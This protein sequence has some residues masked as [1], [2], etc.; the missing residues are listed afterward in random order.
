MFINEL[1]AGPMLAQV[2]AVETQWLDRG[3]SPLDCFEVR[4]G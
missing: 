1:H 3:D 2:T 4:R